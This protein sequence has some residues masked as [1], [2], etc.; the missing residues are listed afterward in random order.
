MAS[1]DGT[2]GRPVFAGLTV[3]RDLKHRFSLL[4]PEG[5]AHAPAPKAAGGGVVFSLAADEPHSFLLV[6]A[7]RLPSKAQ[8]DDLDALRGGLLEGVQQL[9]EAH[10]L[11]ENARVTGPL[12]DAE[13]RHTFRD[14]GS[15][16][17]RQRWVRLLCQDRTQISLVAQGATQERFAYWLPMFTTVMRTVQFADWWAEATG[18]SWRKEL[19]DPVD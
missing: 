3:Y 9:P 12:L 13:A 1:T 16:T 8:P 10:V 15:G 19:T 4:Y 17:V 5:W 7:R 2:R 6:Q 14:A 18:Q 11:E